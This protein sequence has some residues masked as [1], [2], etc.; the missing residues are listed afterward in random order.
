MRDCD[1]TDDSADSSDCSSSTD[2]EDTAPRDEEATDFTGFR[3][4]SV[5]ALHSLLSTAACC[6]HCGGELYFAEVK[7]EGLATTLA[8]SCQSCSNTSTKTLANRVGRFWDVNRQAVFA[9]R[10]IGR[11]RDALCKICGAL[12]MPT[13]ISKSAFDD[14]CKALYQASQQIAEASMTSAAKE[15]RHFNEKEGQD[16]PIFNTSVSFDGTWMRR[17]FSS[18]F[19]VFTAIS[20]DVGKVVDYHVSSKYCHQC[21]IMRSRHRK[22]ELTT[23][24]LEQARNDHNCSKNTDQSSPGMEGEA[25]VVLWQR[26][27]E[28]RGLRYTT[29]IGDGDGKG[30]SAVCAA[31][32]Y[33]PDITIIKEECVGHVQ[34]RVGTN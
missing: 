31:N 14:H 26:S 27:K 16:A 23:E 15:V 21:A 13:P 20:W 33:G 18:K 17:G 19:G 25:A 6:R 4:V 9:M 22:G 3:L 28:R 12:D 1:Y 29:Y 24:E 2:G 10:W 32:P 34:K 30:Y 5:D 11:G 8:L 7:R